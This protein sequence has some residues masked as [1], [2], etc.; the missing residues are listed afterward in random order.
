MYIYGIY[1]YDYVVTYVVICALSVRNF[2]RLT[3]LTAEKSFNL[4]KVYFV[5]N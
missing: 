5:L 1:R 3:S 4:P 2:F